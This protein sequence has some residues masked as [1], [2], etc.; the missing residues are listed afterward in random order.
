M[1][2]CFLV[3]SKRDSVYQNQTPKGDKLIA[4]S[5]PFETNRVTK[6]LQTVSNS[7]S[8]ILVKNKHKN[9]PC[10]NNL[11]YWSKLSPFHLQL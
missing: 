6:L 2:F 9:L 1:E 5:H 4:Y 11:V 8:I 3:Q 7:S 10:C